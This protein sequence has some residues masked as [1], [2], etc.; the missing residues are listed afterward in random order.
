MQHLRN[1]WIGSTE[2]SLTSELNNVLCVS[3]EEID[4]MIRVSSSISSVIRAVDKEFSLSEKYP[5]GHGGLFGECM[6]QRYPGALLLHVKCAAGSRQ[7]L[8]T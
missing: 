1:V 6:L 7:D 4:P 3:L 8:C 2:K 5:K